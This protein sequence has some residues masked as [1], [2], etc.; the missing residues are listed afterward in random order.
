MPRTQAPGAGQVPERMPLWA[1]HFAFACHCCVDARD[2]VR[3]AKPKRSRR[4]SGL[5]NAFVPRRSLSAPRGVRHCQRGKEEGGPSRP[6]QE[7][8]GGG[9]DQGEQR[10]GENKEGKG[11]GKASGGG[12]LRKVL[13]SGCPGQGAPGKACFRKTHR[14]KRR[15]GRRGARC[16]RERCG[17]GAPGW[18][19]PFYV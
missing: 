7:P 15:H 4:P 11:S 10:G 17:V 14:G 2:D 18:L 19:S 13:R 8:P 1:Q 6:P 5:P 12:E 16:A 9:G 3:W